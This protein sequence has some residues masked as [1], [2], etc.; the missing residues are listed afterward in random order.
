MKDKIKKQNN[1]QIKNKIKILP[2]PCDGI[3]KKIKIIDPLIK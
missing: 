1:K 2:N 3:K